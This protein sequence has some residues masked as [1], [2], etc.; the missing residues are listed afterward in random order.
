[1]LCHPSSLL[2]THHHRLVTPCHTLSPIVM[3]CHP[4]SPPCD[5]LSLPITP[6]HPSTRDTISPSGIPS[7]SDEV[8]LISAWHA[9]PLQP[10]PPPPARLARRATTPGERPADDTD[11]RAG[12]KAPRVCRRSSK[13][14]D[15]VSSGGCS[16]PLPRGSPSPPGGPPPPPG[17]PRNHEERLRM[18]SICMRRTSSARLR[19]LVDVCAVVQRGVAA[20]SGLR[21]WPG[22]APTCTVGHGAL[23]KRCQYASCSMLH[24]LSSDL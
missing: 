15:M 24:K 12:E 8:S 4:L 18:R 16:P 17:G 3:L 9:W 10:D 23:M 22:L 6:P 5:S 11:N 14:L 1:M 7:S 2:V 13:L 20:G 21:V 19:L